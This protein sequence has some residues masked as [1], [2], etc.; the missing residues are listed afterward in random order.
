MKTALLQAGAASAM[1]LLRSLFVGM[2]IHGGVAAQPVQLLTTALPTPVAGDGFAGDNFGIAAAVAGD[3][4]VI[5]AYGDTLVAAGF[6]FGIAAGSAYIFERVAGEWQPLQKLA[7]QPIGTD[8]DNYG[9][10]VATTGTTIA[11]GAP[12]RD[13]DQRFE[14]GSVFIYGR[15]ADGYL[16]SQILSPA[17]PSPEQRFGS[18]VALWQDYL[19]VGVP[20]AD[21]GRVDLYRRVGAG[22]YEFDRSLFPQPGGAG[23]FGAAL[24]LADAEL[25]IGAPQADIGGAVYRSKLESAGWTPAQ[26]LALAAVAG[27]ELGSALALDGALALVGAPGVA[28]GSVRVLEAAAG[29]WT[30]TGVIT[31]PGGGVGDRFGSALALDSGRAAVAAVDAL[32]SQGRV[33]LYDRAGANLSAVGQVDIAD[34]GPAKRFGASLALGADGVL[35]GADLDRVGPNR[36]QGSARWFQPGPGGYV[37]TAQLDSGNG[38]MFDRYGTAV[39]VDDGIALVGAYLEDTDSGADAGAAHWFERIAGDWQ[40]GGQITAPDA[41]IEDRFGIAVD[42]DGERMAVGAFWDVVGT[43]VDQG[44]V[45]IFRREGPDWVFEAKLTASDGRPRDY[46]GFA[47]SLDGDR[48]LVGARGASVPFLEQGVAYVFE[49]GVGG[50]QQQAR[51]DLPFENAFAYFGASVALSGDLALVGAPGATLAPGPESAGAAYVFVSLDG[52]WVLKAALQAP[53]PQAG[54]GFGFSLA[55]DADHLLVGAFQ[56]GFAGQGAAYV[57]RS[58]DLRLDGELRAAA[59][60]PGEGLGIAVTLRNGT[61][62]LGASGYDLGQQFNTGTVRTFK[63]TAG[64]WAETE[65]WLAIDGA[66]GDAFGRA[67]AFDG[68]DAVIGAPLRGVDNPLEGHAYAT[69]VDAIFASGF[70]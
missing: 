50:W 68:R 36:G 45:Y 28:V 70:E 21:A 60:Q 54:S 52:G 37:E 7:P 30:Q 17:D 65:Q 64:G 42:V 11:I 40:Y 44:S 9:V 6:T 18:A 12:R 58:L 14:A 16:L 38:A 26:Q 2:L 51:L 33:H 39:A 63:R 13:P 53:Q 4:A 24:A 5:G 55:A 43:N 61:A 41:A 49:R 15:S 23:R 57:Y 3:V 25:L 46:F 22:P 35:I 8:G 66:A 34:D 31:A 48:L 56:E 29:S 59:A 1:L 67:V 10:S 27:E 20:A 62:L 47:L 32:G 69:T 19:A